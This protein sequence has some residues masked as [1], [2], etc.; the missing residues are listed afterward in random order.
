MVSLHAQGSMGRSEILSNTFPPT[1]NPI[2]LCRCH[3]CLGHPTV[4]LQYLDIL[5]GCLQTFAAEG[6]PDQGAGIP[7][8][9][10]GVLVSLATP[11]VN[12]LP[13]VNYLSLVNYLQLSHTP[14]FSASKPKVRI[15][16]LQQRHEGI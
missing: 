6:A 10:W 1:P 13:F 12:Y 9:S 5:T 16:A 4:V 7:D 3:S 14:A 11:L 2:K 8:I 15:A